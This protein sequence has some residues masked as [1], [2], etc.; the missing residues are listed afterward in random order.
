V[1]IN[2]T[3]MEH[4]IQ[5]MG[6]SELDAEIRALSRSTLAVILIAGAVFVFFGFYDISAT[7]P[8]SPI[9]PWIID[10]TRFRSIKVHVAGI[11]VPLGLDDPANV[12]IGV[13]HFAA[14][15]AACHGA[16]GVPK[17]DIARG[18]YPLP[19]DLA[20]ADL[21]YRPAELFCILEHGIKMTGMPAWSDHSDEK[22]WAIVAF[23]EKLPGMNERITPSS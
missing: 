15:C 4:P 7:A 18:L 14:H 1:L 20:K 23:L 2:D 16:P 12:L 6:R 22:L 13:E 3:M 19:P 17:G 5:C 9:T 10:A 8:H 21:L 11:A